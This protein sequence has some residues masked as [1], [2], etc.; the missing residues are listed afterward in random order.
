MKVD[1]R[2]LMAIGVIGVATLVWLLITIGLIASTLAPE[3][4]ALV[5]EQLAP[6]M[7][8]IGVLGAGLVTQI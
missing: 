3:Q 7:A 4:M 5:G 6:R 1:R 2:L 8:L